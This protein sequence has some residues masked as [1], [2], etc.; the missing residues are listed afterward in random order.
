MNQHARKASLI[1][2]HSNMTDQPEGHLVAESADQSA[3]PFPRKQQY[4]TQPSQAE[5]PGPY[6]YIPQVNN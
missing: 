5:P 6:I 2:S 4:G 3:F 1:S